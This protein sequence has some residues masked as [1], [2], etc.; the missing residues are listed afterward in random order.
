MQ[1]AYYA[2]KPSFFRLRQVYPIRTE[3]NPSGLQLESAP[4]GYTNEETS[5]LLTDGVLMRGLSFGNAQ[6]LVLN[7][8]LNLRMNGKI[9]N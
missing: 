2:V 4:S 7:S 8:A 9:N 1:I 3:V 6:D 5:G